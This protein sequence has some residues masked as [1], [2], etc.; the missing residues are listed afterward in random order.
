MS[1]TTSPP[2]SPPPAQSPTSLD[3]ASEALANLRVSL[4]E[5]SAKQAV[6][7]TSPAVNGRPHSDKDYVQLEAELAQSRAEKEALEDK[8]SALVDRVTTLRKTL[9]DKL[10]Q[11]AVSLYGHFGVIFI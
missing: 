10:K 5:P 1:T 3:S 7:D 9:G 11:D 6:A 4:D 2:A 8:Y